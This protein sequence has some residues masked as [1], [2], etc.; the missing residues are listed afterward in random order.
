[1]KGRKID[2]VAVKATITKWR[3]ILRYMW[4]FVQAIGYK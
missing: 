4:M 1:M 3:R 2:L